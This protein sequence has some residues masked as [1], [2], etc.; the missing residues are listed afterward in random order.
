M[1]E[2]GESCPQTALPWRG[3]G[4]DLHHTW[5]LSLP[6]PG[7]HFPTASV[8]LW[9][10]VALADLPTVS[11]PLW[12]PRSRQELRPPCPGLQPCVQS[13]GWKYCWLSTT[14]KQP[15]W[16]F[17][18]RKGC[19]LSLPTAFLYLGLKPGVLIHQIHFTCLHRSRSC[20]SSKHHV[21]WTVRCCPEWCPR[22]LESAVFNFELNLVKTGWNQPPSNWACVS[23]ALW[24]F[25]SEGW[26]LCPQ[27]VLSCSVAQLCPILCDPMDCSLPGSSVH[28]IL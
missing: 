1:T 4:S 11:L 15:P 14:S 3:L 18:S 10:G 17:Q 16:S 27:I 6:A 8:P 20:V 28:G 7:F 21:A 2:R 12:T 26:K 13:Q 22:N 19:T 25:D 24:P 5:P 23:V 9:K